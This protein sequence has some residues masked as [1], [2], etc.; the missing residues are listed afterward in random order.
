MTPHS[1]RCHHSRGD[2][3]LVGFQ[4][5]VPDADLCRRSSFPHWGR[6]CDGHRSG[7]SRINWHRGLV[8]EGEEGSLETSLPEM[9]AG[10]RRSEEESEEGGGVGGGW[11]PGWFRI[12]G[13]LAG[14][15]DI[16]HVLQS[17]IGMLVRVYNLPFFEDSWCPPLPC[18]LL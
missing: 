16:T 5:R 7:Q 12:G 10:I 9:R 4:Y 13:Q 6:T 1:I 3:G 17:H 2:A 15:D 14:L 11:V 18:P 8:G